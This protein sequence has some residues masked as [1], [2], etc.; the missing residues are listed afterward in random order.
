MRE[1][2]FVLKSERQHAASE[3]TMCD[4]VEALHENNDNDN[5]NQR[6]PTSMKAWPCKRECRGHHDPAKKESVALMRLA[7][8]ARCALAHC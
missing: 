8:L 4:C 7:L 5:D 2:K 3:N 1:L 6:S